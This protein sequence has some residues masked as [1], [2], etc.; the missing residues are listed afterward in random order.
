MLT[1]LKHTKLFYLF[2]QHQEKWLE[3]LIESWLVEDEQRLHLQS[4]PLRR[5]FEVYLEHK[6]GK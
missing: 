1:L 4:S 6:E 5:V 3:K 2:S